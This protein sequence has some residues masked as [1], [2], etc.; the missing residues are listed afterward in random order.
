MLADG[1]PQIEIVEPPTVGPTIPASDSLSTTP[2]GDLTQDVTPQGSPPPTD[3]DLGD[4]PLA[5]P[6]S[7]PPPIDDEP[8]ADEQA[9]QPHIPWLDQHEIDYQ[10][11]CA[12]KKE[13]LKMA[14][15]DRSKA[16]ESH[17]SNTKKEA[18]VLQFVDNF[19]RQYVQLYPGRKELLLFPINHFGVRKFVCTTIRP[20]Q[21][22]YKE[23]N[24][25][26]G[27]GRFVADYVAYEALEP[28]HEL[29]SMVPGP[30]Y[31]LKLQ[32]GNSFDLSILLVSLLRG[33]GY[34]AYVVSGYARR[35]VTLMDETETD[36]DAAAT[37][38]D[39][40]DEALP[41]GKPAGKP[42]APQQAQSKYKV[43]A[44]RHLRSMFLMKQEERRKNTAV[45]EVEKN[46]AEQDQ[47]G[48]GAAGDDDDLK[49]LRIHAW[50][51]VLPGKR[52]VAESFF[53]E[54]STGRIYPTD[55]EKYL[56]VESVFSSTNYWVNMQVCYEGLKGISFDLGDNAKWEF[57]LLD[58]TQPG[59]IATKATDHGKNADNGSDDEEEEDDNALEISS[60]FDFSR[61]EAPH[62]LDLPPSWVDV[63]SVSK[64]QFESRCPAGSK[65]V[66]Y[67][68]ARCESFAE[69][70]RPD[71]MTSRITFF[72]DEKKGFLGEIRE[73]FKN[74]KDK[75][76]K[77]LRNPAIDR[78][79][80]HFDPG[81]PHGLKKHV[82][83][84]GKTKEMHFYPSARSDGIL[85]R[86]EE[87]RKVIDYFTER[88]DGLVYR[89]VTYDNTAEITSFRG[90]IVKMT[91][92]FARNP[93][94][95]AHEDPAKKTHFLKED[96]IRVIF[97][98]EDGRIIPSYREFKKP[99]PE[100]KGSFLELNHS[101]E[102]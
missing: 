69:Y 30:T 18:L 43:K 70:H 46:L 92:K 26:R 87:P 77:R 47:V 10:I 38:E 32:T 94:V 56:G 71:G 79:E 55:H 89:S 90:P 83:L 74:R 78:I 6:T 66:T 12:R 65:S 36:A 82:L 96:K 14:L 61:K 58:N 62:I 41:A 68:N 93:A 39:P 80:E 35:D 22:P 4:S 48:D 64:E 45:K 15:L 2:V 85:K 16:P 57:V 37:G 3:P 17:W 28:P 54:P 67:R 8:A 84:C 72:A 76:S 44:P 97:H 24:D 5:V 100:Q 63:I 73:Y 81:R 40:G 42:A 98:L 88:E 19:N 59:G 95:P 102:V 25:Y 50:V 20:T 53:I 21:L 9:P 23:L 27:C 7:P 11:E 75:L 99:T 31:T 86:V 29:P 34:D 60:Y 91:E 101:F 33:V 52:E 49:G 1:E 13:A 51:L